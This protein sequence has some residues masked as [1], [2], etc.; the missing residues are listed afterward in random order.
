MTEAISS[1][2]SQRGYVI[3]DVVMGVVLLALVL[4]TTYQVFLPTFGLSRNASERV[5]RQQDV[6]LAIERIARDLHETTTA[7][8]RL[9]VYGPANGCTG[10]Y[11]GC[12]AFVTARPAC[13]GAFQVTAGSPVWEATIYIWLDAPSSELR[14]RC[15]PT[16][17]FPVATWP[18]VLIPHTVIGTR[19]TQ[20]AFT[21]QPLGSPNP[22]TVAVALREQA[23]TAARP[24]YRYQTEFVNQ[25]IFLPQNR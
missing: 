12:I 10:S 6:R 22:T 9:V 23:A 1:L 19:V 24:S 17:T 15:D 4:L 21:L 3:V 18:P 14:R 16:T 8:N 25:T 7:A 13:T 20:A 11:Q 5:A 2:R